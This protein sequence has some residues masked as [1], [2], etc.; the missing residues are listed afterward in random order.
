MCHLKCLIFSW[1]SI[2]IDETL[3]RSYLVEVVCIFDNLVH[4]NL[5]AVQD[6]ILLLLIELVLLLNRHIGLDLFFFQCCA[7]ALI[8]LSYVVHPSFLCM[9]ESN[10]L[11][12]LLLILQSLKFFPRNF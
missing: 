12:E 11:S 1:L 7:K 8:S 5:V 6:Q 9:I 10:D 4:A 3:D 2:S